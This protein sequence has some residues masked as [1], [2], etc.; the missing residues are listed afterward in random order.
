MNI[1]H[2]EDRTLE[3][4]RSSE[5]TPDQAERV[6]LHAA[7]CSECAC[8]L[9]AME[10]MNALMGKLELESP[11]E[12]FTDRVM[13]SIVSL[14]NRRTPL[15]DASKLPPVQAGRRFA[16]LLRPE[17]YNVAVATAATYLFVST[18]LLKAMFSM[19]PGSVEAELY[20]KMHTVLDWVERI[21]DSIPS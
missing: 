3:L 5:L 7:S 9:E 8:K 16:W 11:R 13:Q 2:P 15:P 20:F 17:L 21:A 4:Y 6:R 18:G 14:E 10:R 1:R 12:D 19:D